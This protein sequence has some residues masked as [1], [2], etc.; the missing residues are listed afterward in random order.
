MTAEINTKIRI[1]GLF[2]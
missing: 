1:K 2:L